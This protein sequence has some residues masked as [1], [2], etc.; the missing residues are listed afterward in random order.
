MSQW[1]QPPGQPPNPYAGS[2]VYSPGGSA[3]RVD[4]VSIAALVCALTCCAAPVAV[5]LGIA[6]IVRTKD[7]RRGGRWAAV[8]GLAFGVLMTL[9]GIALGVFLA[10]SVSQTVWEDE[11]RVGQCLDLDFLD[12][13]TK[14]DCAEPHDGE[15]VAVDQFDDDLVER[16]GELSTEDFCTDV[17]TVGAGYDAALA[18]ERY[19]VIIAIDSFDESDPEAGDWFYCYVVRADGEKLT[20]PVASEPGSR[21]A[22]S[23][24]P[25][26]AEPEKVALT[27][28]RVGDCYDSAEIAGLDDGDDTVDASVVTRTP[29]ARPHDLQLYAVIALEGDDYPGDAAV[30]A[31]ARGCR[32]RFEKF[33]GIP[34]DDSRLDYVSV[35]PVQETWERQGD[36]TITCSV[37]DPD[38]KVS[39]T[40]R[41]HRR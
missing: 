31:A 33:V 2:S 23:P 22:P 28:L 27:R 14:A 16:F 36:R 10:V 9:T 39:G 41:D 40:L 15:I 37:L 11:A 30:E 17:A 13:E 5:G 35:Y 21:A 3:P 25:R 18:N 12:D 1:P 20:G 38:G 8:T 6:G 29:C 26:A 24:Q 19:D 32:A 4:G 34:Y 7:G